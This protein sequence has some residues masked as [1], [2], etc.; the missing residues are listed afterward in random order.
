MDDL[1]IESHTEHEILRDI[2]ETFKTLREINMKLNPKQCA[3]GIEEG[4]FLGYKVNTKGIKLCSDKV[5]VVLA[6]PSPKCLKDIQKLNGKLASLNRFLAKSA[7]KSLPTAHIIVPMEKEELIVYL[8]AAKEA[9]S[10]VLMIER[11][12]KQM[13]IYFVSRVLQ[14][15]EINYT[16]MEKLIGEYDIQYR[17]KTSIKGQILADFIVER[18]EDNPMD[19]PM[20]IKEDLLD[21][22]TLFMN[23]SSCIDAFGAGLIL[24]NSEGA[25]FTYTLRFRFNATNNEAEYEALIVGNRIAEQIEEEGDTWM[26]LIYEY[27]TKETFLMEKEKARA[28]KCKSRCMHAGTR[29]VVEKAIQIGY[30]WQTMHTDARKMIQECQDCQVH[31]PV[32]RNPQQKLTPI[33]SPWP[34]YKWGIYIA[35]PFSEGPGKSSNRD[36]PFSLTYRTEA[37]ILVEIGMLTLRTAEI[38]MV[39][40]DKALEINLDLLEERREQTTIREREGPYEVT[41]ALGNGAYK[42]RDRNVNIL[43]QT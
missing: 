11:E 36:T 23:G 39:Q 14:G 30:Y 19:M 32:P 4:M 40:N 28:V 20:E 37:I 2:E 8:A 10:A 3:I 42:V 31:R 18:P 41:E 21:L 33:M 22:W 27:I 9:M 43:S 17:Q 15:P 24:T 29:S 13:P 1:V 34:F 6:L 16:P 26:T 38:D 25:K 35:R 12:T 5:D 7:E